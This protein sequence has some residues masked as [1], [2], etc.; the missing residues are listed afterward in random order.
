MLG[1]AVV[2]PGIVSRGESLRLAGIEAGLI[3]IGVAL[4]L[5]AAAVIESYLR[6]SHLSSAARLTF[7]GATALFWAIYLAT[8]FQREKASKE[9]EEDTLA[10]AS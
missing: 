7:A 9:M 4:M 1:K 8:G 10:A 6:Q 2:S 5:V 3:C